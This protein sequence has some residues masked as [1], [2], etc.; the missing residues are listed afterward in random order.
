VDALQA[1][2]RSNVADHLRVSAAR[3]FIEIIPRLHDRAQQQY[4]NGL[5][6]ARRIVEGNRTA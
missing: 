1:I 3:R 2:I 4:V 6:D 5:R